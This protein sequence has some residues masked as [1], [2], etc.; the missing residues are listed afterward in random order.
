MSV[1]Q[2]IHKLRWHI[3]CTP[4]FGKRHKNRLRIHSL[5]CDKDT[6]LAVAATMHRR[7]SSLASVLSSCGLPVRVKL[8]SAFSFVSLSVLLAAQTLAACQDAMVQWYNAIVPRCYGTAS[9]VW[10]GSS[11]RACLMNLAAHQDSVRLLAR[12]A[13]RHARTLQGQWLHS[14]S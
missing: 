2:I 8:N 12:Q 5:Q 14:S 3:R 4:S 11:A 6:K 7:F 13:C 1:S 10:K 9:L